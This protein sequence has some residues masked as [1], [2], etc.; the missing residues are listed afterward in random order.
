MYS[1]SDSIKVKLKNRFLL[2]S[3]IVSSKFDYFAG[4]DKSGGYL[5]VVSLSDVLYREVRC[6]DGRE[7]LL[8]SM[9]DR[10]KELL[11]DP[12]GPFFLVDVIDDKQASASKSCQEVFPGSVHFIIEGVLHHGESGGPV[13]HEAVYPVFPY[14]FICYYRSSG[15]FSRPYV[16][17]EVESS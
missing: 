10:Y 2:L 16:S 3:P 12:V 13:Y 15:C 14:H 1:C 11:S 9:V 8:V 17:P 5:A 7:P 6:D 4:L